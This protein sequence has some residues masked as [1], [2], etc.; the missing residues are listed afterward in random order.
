MCLARRARRRVAR[1]TVWWRG[2]SNTVLGRHA[3]TW[4][5]QGISFNVQDGQRQL[6]FYPEFGCSIYLKKDMLITSKQQDAC[7]ILIGPL[8]IRPARTHGSLRTGCALAGRTAWTA[9]KHCMTTF[10]KLFVPGEDVRATRLAR[11][12]K[13]TPVLCVRPMRT[14]L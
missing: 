4:R 12:G 1:F 8:V 9:K 3:G 14:E 13:I 11:T 2:E 7:R 6:P 10:D 5:Y